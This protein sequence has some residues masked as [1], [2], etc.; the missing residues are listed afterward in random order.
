MQQQHTKAAR[1]TG[2]V[3][4]STTVLAL[5]IAAA[6]GAL[7]QAPTAA[8]ASGSALQP[9]EVVITARNRE[10][11]AQSVPIPITV[12]GGDRIA[13]DRAFTVADL[14][15]RAP[16]LT[17]TTPNARRTGVSVRGIGKTS[18]N[19]NM[20]AAVGTIIDDVFYTHVGMTYQD[21]T[22]LERVELLR[23]PQGTLL[24]KNTS[25]GAVKYTTKAPSFTP[26]SSADLETGFSHDSIKL[27]LSHSEGL[28]D[29]V[30]AYR[31][32]IFVDQQDGDIRN[33]NP[34]QG[35]RWHE[36]NRYGGRVKFLWLPTDALSV[37]LNLD[38]A[39][40]RE[41]SNT[42]PFMVD[43]TELS[44]GTPITNS[45]STRLARDYFGGY[46]PIIGS[47]TEIDLD[48]AEPLTTENRGF[49]LV[50]N[51]DL[52]GVDLTSITAARWL[53]FDA[54]NDSEQTRF[55]IAR[56]GTLLDTRQL[57]QEF[58]LSGSAG[59]SFDYQT[60]IYLLNNQ[61][62]TTGRNVY[63]K[64]AGAF[65]ANNTQYT[66]LRNDLPALH[67][68]LDNIIVATNQN[69][70]T[71]SVAVFGQVDWHLS[72][73]LTLTSGLRQ[74]WEKKTNDFT[75]SV[76]RLDGQAL[77]STGN[78]T[79]DAI[80]SSTAGRDIATVEGLAIDDSAVSWL[81][82]PS[83]SLT[84][85]V[86]LYASIADGQKSGAVSFSNNGDIRNVD[87][88][89]TRNYEVGVK[90]LWLDRRVQLNAN[91]YYSTVEDYQNVTS[92]PDPNS[93][94]GYSSRLGNIPELRAQGIE[95]DAN[96]NVAS[97]FNLNL[98]LAYNDAIYTD[99]STATCPRN[100]PSSTPVCDN[101]GKQI[102]GAPRWTGII[103]F[104]YELLLGDSYSAKV[105]G[106]HI[107]RSEHNLEQLLSPYGYQGDYTLTDLGIG[108]TRHTAR[109]ADWELSLVGKNVFNTR[110]TT[111]VNDFS[112]SAPVGYDGIGAQRYV[113]LMLRASFQ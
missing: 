63:G 105:F 18:G 16:G 66:Q 70:E 14:T 20:E 64:D 4:L 24:G 34:A 40:T 11:V 53:K 10:E 68:A 101:T 38:A 5:S 2:S 90:S 78:A 75:R 7:A 36:R 59:S 95:L 47:W 33:V 85:D 22:D 97:G 8:A 84:E 12:V 9:W 82:N 113:G 48:Q 98:G 49:S 71:D 86:L 67:A 41:N 110:Y 61:V 13:R 35:G 29:D 30:L 92:E 108:L 3:R 46:Q 51:L 26:E 69:P 54:K 60:G 58:R 96:I 56:S 89:R 80:R 28:V 94:T 52:G 73:R 23:G 65:Y 31:A 42:K 15:Q 62:D 50:A 93:S 103:G 19:D 107:Y 83:Y 81:I 102:V 25:M 104:D 21:F 32:S 77:V 106:N 1:R 37:T 87:P 17:A 45:Y 91:L 112:N 57:S 79:A 43:P 39:N 100:V 76:S 27:R 72:D 44:D 55:A 6:N 99:W 74:T 88:E 111:S 109:G